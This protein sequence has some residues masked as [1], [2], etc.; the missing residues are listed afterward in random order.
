MEE[1]FAHHV[2]RAHNF[3]LAYPHIIVLTSHFASAKK[4]L[5]KPSLHYAE[6]EVALMANMLNPALVEVHVLYEMSGQDN[7][8]SFRQRLTHGVKPYNPAANL[9]C[10]NLSHQPTYYGPYS[11]DSLAHCGCVKVCPTASVSP[12]EI[13][14]CICTPFG[15]FKSDV[16]EYQA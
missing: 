3:K 10:R 16:S 4:G 5:S 8:E 15:D 1:S 7:C 6:I 14:T 13:Q 11:L 2:F 9:T 12:A